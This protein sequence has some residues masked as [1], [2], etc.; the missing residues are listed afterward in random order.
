MSHAGC[1]ALLS[2]PT[3]MPI[4]GAAPSVSIPYLETPR[5]LLRAFRMGDFD[6]FAANLQDPIATTFIRK[7]ERKDAW[8]IF[9]CST[10]TWILQ[11]AGWWAV[12]VRDTGEHVGTVGAFFREGWPDIEVG[13]SM[14]RAF[15]GRGFASE[16]A[17]EVVRYAFEDR[18]ERRVTAL[19]DAAN[20]A[21]LRVAERVGLVHEADVELWGEPVGRFAK[22]R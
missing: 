12:E 21:S 11:G 19:I 9:G 4:H 6:A 5:L 13:W 10:G 1:G 20:A 15:W 14:Y 18:K 22:A 17:A 3:R 2:A 7:A 8:R 16:A